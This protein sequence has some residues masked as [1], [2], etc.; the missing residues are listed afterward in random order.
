MRTPNCADQQM[1]TH[2]TLV[3]VAVLIFALLVLVGFRKKLE[4]EGVI[5]TQDELRRA[6]RR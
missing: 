6:K 5:Y 1:C 2:D 3:L 4:R